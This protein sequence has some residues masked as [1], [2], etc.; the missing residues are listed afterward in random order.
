MADF[1]YNQAAFEIIGGQ[2]SLLSDTLKVMLVGSGYTPD[3]DHDVVDAGGANDPVDHELNGTG[4]V[5]GWGGSGRQALSSKTLTLDKTNDRVVFDCADVTWTAIDAGT[6]AHA[7]VIKEGATNDT[8][9]R[10]V[11]NHDISVTTNGG[12]LTVQINDLMRFPTV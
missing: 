3:R 8:T 2:I 4:Y 1:V 5:G 10:L 6:V 12:S 9:S 7:I 11:S